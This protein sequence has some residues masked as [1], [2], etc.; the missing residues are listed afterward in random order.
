MNDAYR[1]ARIFVIVACLA[2]VVTGFF[3]VRGFAHHITTGCDGVLERVETRKS[4]GSDDLEENAGLSIDYDS[5]TKQ[6]Y[7]KWEHFRVQWLRPSGE[8]TCND[9]SFPSTNYQPS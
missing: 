1:R 7:S 2:V 6:G 4:A 5:V 8:R 3:I 9:L